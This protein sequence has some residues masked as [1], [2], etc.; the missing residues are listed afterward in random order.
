[1]SA[2][3]TRP[4]V[5]VHGGLVGAQLERANLKGYYLRDVDFSNA[6]LRGADLSGADLRGAKFIRADLSRACLHKA[7]CE[8]ADFTGA[9]LTNAYCKAAKFINAKMV[10]TIMKGIIGKNALFIDADL[11]YADFARAELLGARFNGA[12]TFGIRNINW[13]IFW[14][15]V[16]DGGGKPS[17]DPKPGYIRITESLIGDI[18]IQENSARQP[19]DFKERVRDREDDAN[20]Y[21]PVVPIVAPQD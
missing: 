12:Q 20:D 7:N 6:N 10:C 11:Q 9:D 5:A 15:Y 8:G 21:L 17:Y 13:A 18:S 4:D 3:H 19:V 2:P 1:V 14:W 16:P